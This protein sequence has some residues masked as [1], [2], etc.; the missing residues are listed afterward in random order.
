MSDL[1]TANV[2]E[3]LEWG[4]IS[5]DEAKRADC[6]YCH[7]GAA[8]SGRSSRNSSRHRWQCRNQT[9]VAEIIREQRESQVDSKII[10]GPQNFSGEDSEWKEMVVQHGSDGP[11]VRGG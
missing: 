11:Q 5:R 8:G 7:A 3:Q 1:L 4:I 2:I 10:R 6:K 9:L